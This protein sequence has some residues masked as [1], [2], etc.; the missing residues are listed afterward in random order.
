YLN[1]TEQ[2]INAYLE[3]IKT[4]YM[5]GGESEEDAVKKANQ[6]FEMEKLMAQ[7]MLDAADSGKREPAAGA[8]GLPGAVPAPERHPD[9]RQA[10]NFLRPAV[11]QMAFRAFWEKSERV[12]KLCRV[13]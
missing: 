3:Y 4:L 7:S 12:G 13:R 2:Q 5:L 1:G 10:G 6:F 8:P 11:G 9:G